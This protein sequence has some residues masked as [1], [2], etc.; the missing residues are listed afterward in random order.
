MVVYH[1]RQRGLAALLSCDN[2]AAFLRWLWL[3]YRHGRRLHMEGLIRVGRWC[4]WDLQPQGQ[5]TI[6][7]GS[8]LSEGFHL[9]CQGQVRIGRR[10]FINRDV[11]IAAYEYVEIGDECLLG[12]FVTIHDNEHVTDSREMPYRDQGFHTAPV[13]IGRNVLL[14]AKVS[15]LKGVTIGDDSIVGANAVVTSDIPPGSVAVGVPA[16]LLSIQE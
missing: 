16:R 3:R 4:K 9:F 2:G 1:Q 11:S 5:V 14:G 7:G 12:P 15:V 10:V 6:G 13:K 8:C